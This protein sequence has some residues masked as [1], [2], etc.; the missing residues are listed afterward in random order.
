MYRTARKKGFTLIELL[1]VLAIIGLLIGLLLPAVQK[2]RDAA[3]RAQSMNNLKQLALG[4]HG[5]H[6]AFK[7]FPAS[8]ETF[9][10]A[11]GQISGAWTFLILPFVEQNNVYLGTYG[12]ST[13]YS[14]GGATIT[15]GVSDTTPTTWT[16]PYNAYQAQRATGEIA[17]FKS[18]RDYTLN[19]PAIVSGCSYLAN[20][21]VLG[22]GGWAQSPGLNIDKIFDGTSN[23]ILLSEAVA[24]CSSFQDNSSPGN[25]VNQTTMSD[26]RK[27][28]YDD[29][30]SYW[31]VTTVTSSNTP[32]SYVAVT[33][34]YVAPM[35]DIVDGAGNVPSNPV[36]LDDGTQVA[37]DVMPTTNCHSQEYPRPQAIDSSGM[38][39]VMADGSVRMVSV[40][41]SPTTFWAAVTPAGVDILGPDW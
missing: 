35:F 25:G 23:T 15:N 9:P 18:P 40:N 29:T 14:Y 33:S 16:D 26:I 17:I 34:M 13:H 7:G 28:N 3:A 41:V 1:I 4:C 5:Y 20:G 30:Y 19:N 2:V 36:T 39:V 24:N 31:F 6:D 12:P 38:L 11:D 10:N 8:W 37:F 27:W 21:T 32:P 22:S